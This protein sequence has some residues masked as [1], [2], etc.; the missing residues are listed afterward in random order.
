MEDFN[1]SKDNIVTGTFHKYSKKQRGLF[2]VAALSALL[3]IAIVIALVTQ[4]NTQQKTPTTSTEQVSNLPE[5]LVSITAEGFMPQTITVKKGQSVIW[6]NNDGAPH[7]VS[8]D[9]HPTEDGLAG[10]AAPA[11]VQPNESYSFTFEE[12]GTYTYHD[13]LNPEKFLGTVVVE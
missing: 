11:P 10:F 13:H 8:T 12:S 3:V 7:Q 5:A 4:N 2:L 9:P 6:T 1:H